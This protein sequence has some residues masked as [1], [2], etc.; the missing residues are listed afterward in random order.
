MITKSNYTMKT[1]S[2]TELKKEIIRQFG[3]VKNLKTY[4]KMNAEYQYGAHF[5][6]ITIY[7]C[8][9]SYNDNPNCFAR[10]IITIPHL[11]MSSQY[12]LGKSSLTKAGKI[13]LGNFSNSHFIT[14]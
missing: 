5:K 10:Y 4:L 2:K 8:R 7:G 12:A 13:R 3:S 9:I 1:F 6:E 14:L 11:G